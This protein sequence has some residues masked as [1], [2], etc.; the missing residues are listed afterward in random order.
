[1]RFEEHTHIQKANEG[2]FV[3]QASLLGFCKDYIQQDSLLLLD[4][5]ISPF[6]HIYF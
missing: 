6:Q 1:M 4:C 3:V 2:L 5:A